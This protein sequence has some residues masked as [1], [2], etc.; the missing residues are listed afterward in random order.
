MTTEC[1]RTTSRRRLILLAAIVGPWAL[2]WLGSSVKTLA[3]ECSGGSCTP[4]GMGGSGPSSGGGGITA[5]ALGGST[6]QNLERDWRNRLLLEGLS[7][8]AYK[9][10]DA[11]AMAPIVGRREGEVGDLQLTYYA[12]FQVDEYPPFSDDLEPHDTEFSSEVAVDGRY[13]LAESTQ[14]L[15]R[16]SL[17]NEW[18]EDDPESF[19]HY[20]IL[21][22]RVDGG[23]RHQFSE[24]L[25]GTLKLGGTFVDG[26]G[27]G[28]PCAGAPDPEMLYGAELQYA[29]EDYRIRAGTYR[30]AFGSPDAEGY[31]LARMDFHYIDA[32]V[33]VWDDFAFNAQGSKLE[34]TDDTEDFESLSGRCTYY[35]IEESRL[36]LSV[37]VTHEFRDDDETIVSGGVEW[38]GLLSERNSLSANAR[39]DAN[40]STE[41]REI[42]SQVILGR[43]GHDHKHGGAVGVSVQWEYS[44][45]DRYSALVFVRLY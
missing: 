7:E 33:R 39:F 14:L 32:N 2:V 8:D 25:T 15:G 24:E 28:L 26:G 21:R 11:A 13:Q 38:M 30:D 23:V 37:G 18:S 44:V 22:Y 16:L 42:T 34:F 41:E 45:E 12:G 35:P 29:W 40:T 4:P 17:R 31:K 9:E 20:D 36:G 19:P 3:S 10:T 5:V 1:S 43:T 27:D 6:V